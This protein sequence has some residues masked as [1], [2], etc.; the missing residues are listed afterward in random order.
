MND[1]DIWKISR[2][3]REGGTLLMHK[4][5]LK[6]LDKAKFDGLKIT[7]DKSGFLIEGQVVAVNPNPSETT[8]NTTN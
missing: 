8:L 4:N 6:K 3:L 2:F 7:E 5:D 1:S